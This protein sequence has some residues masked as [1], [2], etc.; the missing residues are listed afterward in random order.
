M[1]RFYRLIFTLYMALFQPLLTM[2]LTSS[3]ELMI[4]VIIAVVGL[5]MSI[6]MVHKE[7]TTS[8]KGKS[9][10]INEKNLKKNCRKKLRQSERENHSEIVGCRL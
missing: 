3:Y 4:V 7:K 10:M 6:F 1:H 2:V 8:R 9:D 5:G